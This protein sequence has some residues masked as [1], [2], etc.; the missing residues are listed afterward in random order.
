MIKLT[1]NLTLD[2]INNKDKFHRNFAAKEHSSLIH[3][4]LT[5]PSRNYNNQVSNPLVVVKFDDY[6]SI[7]IKN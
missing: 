7:M 3:S 1:I 6:I 5:K 2:G 4:S